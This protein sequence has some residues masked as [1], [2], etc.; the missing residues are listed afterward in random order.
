[1]DKLGTEFNWSISYNLGMYI[2]QIWKWKTYSNIGKVCK[3]KCCG[4]TIVDAEMLFIRRVTGS[5]QEEVL[6]K[7][8]KVYNENCL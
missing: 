6:D 5:S 2:G 1:M 4:H 7:L 8:I 3:D